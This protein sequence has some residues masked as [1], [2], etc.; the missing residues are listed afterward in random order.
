MPMRA[1]QAVFA[2][3]STATI[4]RAM[5]EHRPAHDPENTVL[6]AVLSHHKLEKPV[7]NDKPA[8]CL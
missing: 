2:L 4:P 5:H 3:P 8:C 7:S 6:D 1:T